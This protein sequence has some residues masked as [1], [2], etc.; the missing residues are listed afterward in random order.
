MY[1]YKSI[2]ECWLKRVKER[3]AGYDY[4]YCYYYCCYHYYGLACRFVN[5]V[6]KFNV[7]INANRTDHKCV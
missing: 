6:R 2:T 7:R 3:E 1:D 5:A 4:Y